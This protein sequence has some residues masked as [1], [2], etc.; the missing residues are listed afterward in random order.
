MSYDVDVRESQNHYFQ[1]LMFLLVWRPFNVGDRVRI[2][3]SAPMFVHKLTIYFTE[4]KRFD[5]STESR[6]NHVLIR[7]IVRNEV[8]AEFA[9]VEIP[10]KIGYRTSSLQLDMLTSAVIQWIRQRRHVWKEDYIEFYIYDIS[11]NEHMEIAFWFGH[12]FTLQH[13]GAVW[14]DISKLRLYLVETMIRLGMECIKAAQPVYL[15]SREEI[16]S[17]LPPSQQKRPSF[18]GT[19]QGR[20][21][22]NLFVD[23][24]NT[25]KGGEFSRE[26]PIFPADRHTLSGERPSNTSEEFYELAENSRREKNGYSSAERQFSSGKTIQLNKNGQAQQEAQANAVVNGLL[27]PDSNRER[28][29]TSFDIN[30]HAANF[31]DIRTGGVHHTWNWVAPL[32]Q[33]CTVFTSPELIEK[34]LR[35]KKIADYDENLL[36]GAGYGLSLKYKRRKHQKSLGSDSVNE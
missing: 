33:R 32:R 4:F 17:S 28:K 10:I 7:S 5:G 25:C 31:I 22:S 27:R 12:R 35:S 15:G 13:G 6:A 20:H 18:S 30:A 3:D 1:G 14:G 19:Q 26:N 36:K 2:D 29:L 21:P 34:L 11:V 24:A 9:V 23:K 16:A 8:R